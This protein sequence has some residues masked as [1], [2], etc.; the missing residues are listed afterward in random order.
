[1]HPKVCLLSLAL[2][3]AIG[4]AGCD[5]SSSPDDDGPGTGGAGPD[6]PP[7]SDNAALKLKAGTRFSNDVAQALDLAPGFC[8]ELGLAD[9]AAVHFIILG[10][11]DAF[12]SGLYEP[13]PETTATS[14]L[15]FDRIALAGCLTRATTDLENPGEATIFAGLAVDAD[16]G[17]DTEAPE[18]AA[19]VERL[20][21]KGLARNPTAGEVQA[22]LGMYE[23]IEEQ[24]SEAPAH[25]WATLGCFAVLTSMENIFY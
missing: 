3:V 6:L 4:L 7:T 2:V 24:G 8:S 13:L 12:G 16:G 19:A 11:A 10:G 14:P 18:A 15:A 20:Y 25:D 23:A 9:C 5:D 21:R 22:V 1:V 17:M